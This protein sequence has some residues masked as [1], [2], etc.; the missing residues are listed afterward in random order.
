MRAITLMILGLFACGTA[1]AQDPA[2]AQQDAKAPRVEEPLP[3]KIRLSDDG[4]DA[5]VVTIH[6]RDS[7]DIVEEYRQNGRLYMV[8]VRPPN[9][10]A[11]T[12]VDT[13]GDGRLDK[14]DSEGPIGPVYY[15][16]YKWN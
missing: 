4:A 13:N 16:I 8:K 7:G 14:S 6:K 1:V 15:T 10:I 11:Y 12:L 2:P 5:P 9:G 3:E